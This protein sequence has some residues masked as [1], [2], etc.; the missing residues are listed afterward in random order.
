MIRALS[1]TLLDIIFPPICMG[2][3]RDGSSLCKECLKKAKKSIDS[4]YPF[5]I[6]LYSFKD[7]LI[8]RAIHNIKY[9]HRKDLLLPLSQELADTLSRLQIQGTLLPIPMHP[10]RKMIRGHNQAEVL[11]KELSILSG[12]SYDPTFLVRSLY[13]RQQ[14]KTRSRKERLKNQHN[15]FALQKEPKGMDYILVDDV[16]TTGAT[17]LEARNLLLRGGARKVYAITLAH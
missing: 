3:R 7:P 14:V 4:P 10:I 6:T 1:A 16:T 5:I 11:A 12:L 8:R 2:C 9:F 15:A 17:L 13:R